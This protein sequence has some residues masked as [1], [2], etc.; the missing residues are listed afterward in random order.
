[1]TTGFNWPL[2]VRWS[3]VDAQGVV[4]N[5]NYFVYADVAA[6]EFFRAAGVMDGDHPDMGQSYVVDARATF[7][8]SARFDDLLDIHVSVPR[9]GRSSYELRVDILRDGQRLTEVSLTYV[10]A[11]DGKSE[12]LSDVFRSTLASVCGPTVA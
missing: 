4:F 5:P 10:R 8:G 2:R 12:P 11:L 1:M 7:R 6:T 9:I 3:E